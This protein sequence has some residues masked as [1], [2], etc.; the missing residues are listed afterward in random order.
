MTGRVE[1]PPIRQWRILNLVELVETSLFTRQ[2]T[3][4]LSDDEYRRFQFLLAANPAMG[5]LI[6]GGA[7]FERFALG[8]DPEGRVEALGSS[9]SGRCERKLSCSF[10]SSQRTWQPT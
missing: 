2:I 10:T 8:L 6:R 9:T 5:P 4:L 1:S 3:G 7:V